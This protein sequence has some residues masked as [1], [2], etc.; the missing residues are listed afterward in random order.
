MRIV[1]LLT[2]VLAAA[3]C[4]RAEPDV[5]APVPAIDWG[6]PVDPDGDCTF[7]T[8]PAELAI[9]LPAVD[10]DLSIERKRMNA[11][12]SLRPVTGDFVATVRVRGTFAPSKLS[13]AKDR[14]A[15][16]G[17]GL[18]LM[19]DD[20]TYLRL[21]RA[22]AHTGGAD[23]AYVSWEARREGTWTRKGNTGE[24]RLYQ[25][26]T[27]LRLIRRGDRV[28]PAFSQD[29]GE[30]WSPLDEVVLSLPD[31]VR[32]GVAA[33]TTGTQAFRPVF[34]RFTVVPAQ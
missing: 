10:K 33:V 17:A 6:T 11:P 30:T 28:R 24:A 25:A 2:F 31:E 18:V 7:E 12:R 34:D 26:D 14:A 1:V 29:G 4:G 5:D 8:G 27:W 9:A 13:R 22:A 23:A 20:R 15:F 3:G 19:V 32:I 21:E 16:V